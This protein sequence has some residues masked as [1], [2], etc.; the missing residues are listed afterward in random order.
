MSGL[1]NVM[2]GN[3]PGA[4]PLLSLLGLTIDGVLRFRDA[5]VAERQGHRVIAVYT[6]MGGGNRW[7]WDDAQTAGCQCYSH[8][9]DR[10]LAGHDAYL[11]DEDDDFDS[12]YTTY[13]FTAP[14]GISLG[15]TAGK[16][17]EQEMIEPLGGDP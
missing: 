14:D 12:T 9:A 10:V 15:A 11:G 1:Y 16:T 6:R 7:C 3:E 5:P 17:P 13:Y 8:L 4:G 2:V